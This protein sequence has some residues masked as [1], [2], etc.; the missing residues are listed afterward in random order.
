MKDDGKG[1]GQVAGLA[2]LSRNAAQEL[3]ER[4]ALGSGG[5]EGV[6]P[7]TEVVQ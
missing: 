1:R 6:L 5:P 2:A 4:R 7:V 3:G